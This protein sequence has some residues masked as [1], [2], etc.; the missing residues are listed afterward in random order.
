MA[1]H[2]SDARLYLSCDD[3]IKCSLHHLK[4]ICHFPKSCSAFSKIA[5]EI[6][7]HE[8]KCKVHTTK[9]DWE[10]FFCRSSSSSD[11]LN[12]TYP[13]VLP[14]LL[15]NSSASATPVSSF[16]C[17]SLS[18]SLRK[19]KKIESHGMARSCPMLINSS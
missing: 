19:K 2:L 9:M 14:S 3:H 15:V 11:L 16:S 4:T 17:F 13:L 18:L 5:R 12:M 8:S 1:I 10:S 6:K 7:T